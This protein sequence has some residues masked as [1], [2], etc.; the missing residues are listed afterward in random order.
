[1]EITTHQNST[2][3][4]KSG[5]LLPPRSATRIDERRGSGAVVSVGSVSVNS[6]GAHRLAVAEDV[7]VILVELR[8]AHFARP[9]DDRGSGSTYRAVGDDE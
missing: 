1:M 9:E 7:V 2:V 6:L 3:S 8:E 5:M 4:H